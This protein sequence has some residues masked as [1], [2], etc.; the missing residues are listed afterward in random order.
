ML[1]RD[2]EDKDLPQVVEVVNAF[3]STTTTEWT[4]APYTL[5]DR[6]AWLAKHRQAAEPVIVAEFNG[7]IAGFASYG[8]FRDSQKWPG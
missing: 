5:E 6:R 8:D 2:A 1:V 4:E 7:E 3:L